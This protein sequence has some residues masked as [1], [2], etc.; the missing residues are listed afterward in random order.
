VADFLSMLTSNKN[1]PPVEDSFLDE[2]LFAVSS[3]SPWFADITN[4]LAAGRLLH[5]LSLKERHKIIKQI[6]IFSCIDDCLFHTRLDLIIKRCVQEYEIQEI[7][8]DC[9]EICWKGSFGYNV[10]RKNYV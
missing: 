5:H 8:K 10:G 7:L 1:E 9:H 6:W 3:K 2:N 4:H